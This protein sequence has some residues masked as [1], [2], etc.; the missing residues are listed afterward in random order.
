LSAALPSRLLS[1]A[2]IAAAAGTVVMRHYAAG[3]ETRHKADHSP[4]TDADEEA[5]QLILA[6][7]ARAF[8]GVPVVAEE[9]VAAG[10]RVETG[11]HFFLVDPLD[12]T[13]EFLS[14]N[15]EFTVNIGEV[16]GGVP[17]AG[18]VYAPAKDRMFVGASDTG[19]FETKGD[20]M[21]V[22]TIRARTAPKDGLVAVGSRS[23]NDAQTTEF[24]KQF[25]VKD[26]VAAGSSLKFCMIAAGEADIYARAGRTMEW[27]TAAGHALLLA[28][29]GSL[30][31]WDGRAFT[32]GKPSFENPGFVAKGL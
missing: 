9:E 8:P 27:D 15:G 2:A 6:S 16:R 25:A 1:L 3:T 21:H 29:G 10:R 32:Y 23:H 30:T 7:L 31:H 13:R 12:G 19:S 28:S 11:A 14:G 26:F 18:V 24:L 20:L 17:V 22:K 4:V 5:E